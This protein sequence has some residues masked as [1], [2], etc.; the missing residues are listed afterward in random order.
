VFAPRLGDVQLHVGASGHWRDARDLPGD[1]ITTRYRQRPLLHS[2]DVRFIAT[3]SLAI[4]SETH[5]GIE[6]AVIHGPF[7][8]AGEAHWFEADTTSAG[9]SPGFFGGYAEIGFFLTGESRGYRGGRFDRTSVAN[10]VEEGGIGAFQ[11]NLRYDYL[12]LSSGAVVGGTQNGVQG[13]LIWIPTD[14]VRFMLNYAR[15]EYDDAAIATAG[16]D[17]DYGVDVFGARAQIDF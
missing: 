12:D 9:F 10:P 13:S 11:L 6:A 7:H 5:Y 16:G 1:G 2:T 4:E 15:L 14:Y 3:P 17:R 8:A